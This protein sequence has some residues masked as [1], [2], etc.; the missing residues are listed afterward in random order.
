MRSAWHRI[1]L[2]SGTKLDSSALITKCV[3]ISFS[4]PAEII[5]KSHTCGSSLDGP[6]AAAAFVTVAAASGCRVADVQHH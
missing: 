1:A 5:V 4:E 2:T 3:K 6:A